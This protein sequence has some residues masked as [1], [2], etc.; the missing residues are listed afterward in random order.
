MKLKIF[1]STIIVLAFLGVA[2]SSYAL[3]QHYAPPETSSCD[4]NETISCTAINQSEYSVLL[5][6]PVAGLGMAG[7]ALIAAL[8]VTMMAQFHKLQDGWLLLTVTIV[9]LAFSLWLTWIEIFILKAVCP[10]CVMS[11]LMITTITVLA[12]LVVLLNR[13]EA[14]DA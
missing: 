11:L 9:A 13:G 6:M 2:D 1:L 14:V 5:G 10:L 7:Y 4:V 12:L 3:Y 8:A